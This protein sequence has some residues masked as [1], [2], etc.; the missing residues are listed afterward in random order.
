MKS[1]TK[2]PTDHLIDLVIDEYLT[3][4]V[5]YCIK[6]SQGSVDEQ[7]AFKDELAY[8][9]QARIHET[10]SIYTRLTAIRHSIG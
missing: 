3:Q 2:S 7:Q 1:S 9:I 5:T 10:S 4:L 8:Q 6:E